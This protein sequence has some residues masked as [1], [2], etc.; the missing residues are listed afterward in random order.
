MR[1]KG[2]VRNERFPSHTL[3]FKIRNA[4]GRGRKQ[5]QS[6]LNENIYAI[7]FVQNVFCDFYNNRA[8]PPLR[9]QD[10]ALKFN[11]TFLF[12]L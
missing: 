1:L 11:F 6:G 10:K 9:R 5:D 3:L 12:P 4:V 2:K 8:P 7:T